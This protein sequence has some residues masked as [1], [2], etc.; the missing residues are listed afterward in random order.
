[1]LN[2]SK[3]PKLPDVP[4]HKE[5]QAFVQYGN[6]EIQSLSKQFNCVVDAEECAQEWSSF[7]QYFHDNCRELKHREVIQ[8]LCLDQ[9]LTASVYPCM[10]KL[11]KICR[12][13]PIHTADVERTFSQL[14]L[15]KSDIRNRMCE[16]TLDALLRIVIEGPSVDEYP[17]AEAVTLWAKKKNRRLST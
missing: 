5:L 16:K 9:S 14:K 7:R 2:P 12:V 3:L 6:S 11:A 15:I 4:S 17:I 1:M 10:S 13:I 8:Y